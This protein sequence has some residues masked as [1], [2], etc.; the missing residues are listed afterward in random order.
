MEAMKAKSTFARSAALA[1]LIAG[2]MFYAANRSRAVDV[3]AALLPVMP[4]SPG[5]NIPKKSLLIHGPFEVNPADLTA[6]G[7]GSSETEEA[8]ASIASGSSGK[9]VGNGEAS[10]PQTPKPMVSFLDTAGLGGGDPGVAVSNQY[11]L[12]SDEVNGIALYDKAG[13]LVSSTPD[14]PFANPF[15]ID[16]LFSQVQKDINAGLQV[17][18]GLPPGFSMNLNTYGDVRIMFDSYRKRFWIYAMAKNT[19]P[20]DPATIVNYPAVKLVRRDKAAVAV[21]KTEDPRDGFYTYWWNET[22]HNGECN[23]AAGCSDPVFKTSGEGADYPSIG[24]SPKYFLATIGVNRRDPTFKTDTPELAKAWGAGCLSKFVADGKTFDYCGPFYVNLM[25]A[26]ADALAS[27]CAGA[28]RSGS[29]QCATGRAY[30]LFVDAR[31][32]VTD[33][34]ESGDFT[35][36]MARGVK[37]VVMHGP[38]SADAYF[39]NNFIDRPDNSANK[40][41][42]AGL[43]AEIKDLSK[44]LNGAQLGQIPALSKQITTKQAEIAEL[45]KIRHDLVVWSLVGDSLIPTLYPIKPFTFDRYDNW[46]FVLNASA[47]D[48]KLYSTFNQCFPGQ[49][50]CFLSVRVLRVNTLTGKTEIDRTLGLNNNFDDNPSDR[51][52]YSF[53]GI[54]ANKNGDMVLVYTRYSTIQAQQRQEV[55]FSVWYH[56]E[57]DVRPSRLLKSG[58]GYYAHGTDTAGIAVDPSDDESIWMAQIFAARAS[59]GNPYRRIAVGRVFGASPL[60]RLAERDQAGGSL[61]NK[62]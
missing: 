23:V 35:P 36:S 41:K 62:K 26:D 30:P 6:A 10:G 61:R 51:F 54:E 24:I 45:K 48:G 28:R 7:G 29:P 55:R 19:P 42:I 27:G 22:I 3:D 44:A 17:P 14:H 49:D 33:R 12:V 11:V 20:W 58:D 9:A 56:N 13:S 8:P 1:M 53:P 4:V 52:H 32:F 15:R 31:N 59:N 37:P 5:P 47:R 21:S 38:Q 16:T 50:T 40:A 43:E 57:A 18:A 25:V 34:T 60:R 2:T 39:V 46:R